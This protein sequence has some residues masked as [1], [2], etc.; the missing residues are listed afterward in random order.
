MR[1]I[2]L[3]L[4]SPC[5]LLGAL[6]ALAFAAAP[7]WGQSSR[8]SLAPPPVGRVLAAKLPVENKLTMNINQTVPAPTRV[9]LVYDMT[10]TNSLQSP[11]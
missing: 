7:A 11:K 2:P 8:V 10:A 1:R 9:Q 6:L 4:L 5:C 3:P